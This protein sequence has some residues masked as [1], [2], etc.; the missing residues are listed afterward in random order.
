MVTRERLAREEAGFTLPEMMVTITVMMVVL[1]ALYNIFD[2]SM[3]IFSFGNNKVE[4]VENARVGLERMEREVRAAYPVDRTATPEQDHVFFNTSNPPA[5]AM[6][7][8]TQITFGN[9]SNYEDGVAPENGD[10]KI[11]CPGGSYP[12]EYISYKLTS[13]ANPSVTCTAATAPP[14]TL[15]RV[16]TANVANNGDPLVESVEPG[17]LQFRYFEEDGTTEVVPPATASDSLRVAVVRVSMSV[18]VDQGTRNEATQE[19]TT[20]I[21]LRNR[22][23]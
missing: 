3:R 8:A 19:L 16:N 11:R 14:C 23:N 21:Q 4:A 1:F 7:T 10:K 5:P 20:D 22:G 9:E 2:M 17:S 13:T 6:P 18:I 12:C 15:R